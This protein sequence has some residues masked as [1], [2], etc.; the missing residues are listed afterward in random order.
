MHQET[1]LFR[2][3]QGFSN[4]WSLTACTPSI[5]K[6]LSPSNSASLFAHSRG[7]NPLLHPDFLFNMSSLGRRQAKDITSV[8]A[9]TAT[10]VDARRRQLLQ[11]KGE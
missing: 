6:A 3:P 5:N 11:D 9:G 8:R 1:V 4:I 7:L 10:A 2:V